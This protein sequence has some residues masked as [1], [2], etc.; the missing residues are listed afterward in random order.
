ML[1]VVKVTAK[2]LLKTL[3]CENTANTN[4]M[5]NFSSNGIE[6]VK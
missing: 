6:E 4:H 1:T 3:K 2:T 5:K